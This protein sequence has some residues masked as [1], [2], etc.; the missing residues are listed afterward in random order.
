M[1]LLQ[2]DTS[3]LI[4]GY[5]WRENHSLLTATLSRSG[6]GAAAPTTG[7]LPPLLGAP[8]QGAGGPSHLCHWSSGNITYHLCLSSHHHP[9]ERLVLLYSKTGNK[10][11]ACCLLPTAYCLLHVAC[12]MLPL[13]A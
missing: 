2:N 3:L 10:P 12:C 1:R 11:I 4:S 6:S 13:A 7:L 9:S 5:G 8:P